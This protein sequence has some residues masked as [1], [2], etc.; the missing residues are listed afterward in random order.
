MMESE[1]EN[2]MEAKVIIEAG[3]PDRLH[4][5][6]A[7]LTSWVTPLRIVLYSYWLRRTSFWG[8]VRRFGNWFEFEAAQEANRRNESEVSLELEP[9]GTVQRLRIGAKS[10]NHELDEHR[11][12]WTFLGSLGIQTIRLDARL[13]TNQI[14][15]IMSLL[16]YHRDIIKKGS[17][18]PATLVGQLMGPEGMHVACTHTSLADHT[19]TVLYT[20]CTLRFS[21]VVHWFERHNRKFHDHRTLFHMAPRYAVLISLLVGAPGIVIAAAL[22]H[23]LLATVLTSTALFLLGLIYMFFMV[24][25]S[26]EYDNEEKAYNLSRAYGQLREY[27]DRIQ[28]DIERA[29]TVQETFLPNPSK[30]PFEDKIDWAMS[31]T[32]AEE[33]GGDYFD[34]AELDGNRVAI[35]FTDVSGHGMGAA[36]ITAVMKTTFRAWLDN[37]DTLEGLAQQ[38]NANL[39]RLVPLGSF[40]AAFVA[41]YDVSTHRLAY[42]NCGHQPEPWRLPGEKTATIQALSE[43]RNLIMGIQDQREIATARIALAPND[44]I[45]FV[46]DGIVENPNADG[47]LY[48]MERFAAFLE[49]RRSWAPKPLVEAISKEAGDYSRGVDQSDDRT[50]LALRI[51]V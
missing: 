17:A 21:R 46:S 14:E 37:P 25:G 22:G 29:R 8:Q 3:S 47:Q 12:L 50:I 32:P 4:K 33:V 51:R 13:E 24:V 20:Y 34:V 28:T 40:A 23:W 43:A 16:H 30:M 11:D 45:L 5:T 42:A 31:F 39:L 10:L 2:P 9:G 36:F 1:V 6:G 35:L 49:A 41:I 27:T 44:T 26:V 7:A 15:D 19:L 18:G 38:M 48:G